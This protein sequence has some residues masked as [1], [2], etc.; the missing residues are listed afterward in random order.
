MEYRPKSSLQHQTQEQLDQ[1][2]ALSF[3]MTMTMMMMMMNLCS[4][5]TAPQ[6]SPLEQNV[7]PV[8]TFRATQPPLP[9][10]PNRAGEREP[11]HVQ[12]RALGFSK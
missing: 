5:A 12:A 2:H 6:E 8:L 10:R 4:H 3:S 11:Q 1:L 9:K 7:R